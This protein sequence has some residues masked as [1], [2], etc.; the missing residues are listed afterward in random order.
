MQSPNTCFDGLLQSTEKIRS[1]GSTANSPTN[2]ADLMTNLETVLF[3][4]NCFWSLHYS[5]SHNHG[6]VENGCIWKVTTIGRTHLWLPWLWEEVYLYTSVRTSTGTPNACAVVESLH[7]QGC[8]TH[9]SSPRKCDAGSV[10]DKG[11]K[12]KYDSN[13]LRMDNMLRQLRASNLSDI[14]YTSS[15]WRIG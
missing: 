6:S 2:E 4:S 9:Q 13:L 7:I 5:F 11:Y 10:D 3:N 12:E 8:M 15:Q 14:I 1:T